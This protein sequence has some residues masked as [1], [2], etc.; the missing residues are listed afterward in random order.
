VSRDEHATP[1]TPPRHDGNAA[2]ANEAGRHRQAS[3]PAGGSPP[4]EA[5]ARR[6]ALAI[7][8]ELDADHAPT[9]SDERETLAWL[10]NRVPYN[11]ALEV[12]RE[13]V[14]QERRINPGWMPRGLYVFNRWVASMALRTASR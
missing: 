1:A 12:V 7:Y 8:A 2:N 11:L 13:L 3:P 5:D 6:L 10:Q 9:P 14:R 4:T